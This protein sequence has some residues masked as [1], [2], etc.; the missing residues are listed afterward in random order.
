MSLF[1]THTA[2]TISSH[3]RFTSARISA[4]P[5]I[6]RRSFYLGVLLLWMMFFSA[7][8]ISIY[9][10]GPR[11]NDDSRRPLGGQSNGRRLVTTAPALTGEV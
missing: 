2:T 8:A 5:G 3:G 7:I 11:P 10:F 6:L 4:N 9:D 1:S